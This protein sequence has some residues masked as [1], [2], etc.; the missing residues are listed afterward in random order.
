MARKANNFFG[1]RKKGNFTLLIYIIP[2]IRGACL[3][4]GDDYCSSNSNQNQMYNQNVN[5]KIF[6]NL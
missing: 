1:K 5:Q 2:N 4:F 6:M 3:Y